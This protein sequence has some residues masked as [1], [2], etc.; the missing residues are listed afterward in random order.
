MAVL[1]VQNI[2]NQGSRLGG[3]EPTF[4]SA[5]TAGDSFV[6]DGNTVLLV[7][8]TSGADITLTVTAASDVNGRAV[9]EVFTVGTASNGVSILGPFPRDMFN[10]GGSASFTYSAVG[11]LTVAPVR[12]LALPT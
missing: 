8:N 4:A 11:S 12:L 5:G 3:L 6:N 1:S 2:I 9:D 7:D 10:V